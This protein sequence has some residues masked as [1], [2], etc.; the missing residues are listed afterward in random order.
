MTKVA[1]GAFTLGGTGQYKITVSNAGP[2]NSTGVTLV[3]ETFPAGITGYAINGGSTAGWTCSGTVPSVSCSNANSISSGGNSMLLL[4]VTI[5]AGVSG[6]LGA[7]TVA[8]SNPNECPTCGAGNGPVTTPPTPVA[9]NFDLA[10][11]KVAQGTFTPG[12]SGQYRI[13]VS[14]AGP[15][16]STG[17][18]TVNE[19]FPAGI[20]GYTLNAGLSSPGWTCS[21]TV[22][23]VT[24]T[25]GNSIPAG[26][27]SMLVL[28]VTLSPG[29]SNP[30]GGNTVSISNP[31]ECCPAGNGPV[32]TPPT[33][34]TA[35][36]DLSVAKAAQGT[37]LAG[38]SGQY[39]ITVSN[40][41][42]SNST[43]TTTVTETLPTGITGYSVNG[44][45]TPGWTCTGTV[46]NVTCAN[47]NPIPASG[48]S[49]LFLDVTVAS[50]A[51]GNLP[52]NQVS[53]SNPNE[54]PTCG[55]GNGPVTTPPTPVST[56]F[57]L[58]A[59]KTSVGAFIAGGTGQYRVTITNAGPSNSSGV[60]TL[61]DLLPVGI[62]G[63]SVNAASSAGWTCSGA[64]PGVTCTN[65]SVIPA[66][67]NIV[68]LLNVTISPNAPN[69]LGGN[70]VSISN[71]NECATCTGD[72]GPITTP[73][74]TINAQF[75]LAIAKTAQGT[76][77]AGGSGQ[78]RITVTN[79]GPS[80]SNGTTTVTD[81]LPTGITGYA[82]NAGS[83]AGWVCSG[84]VPNI[85]CT[86]PNIIASGG[87]SVLLLDVMISANAP[88]PLGTNAATVSNPSETPGNTG[89]NGPVNSGGPTP[90][91]TTFDLTTAKTAQGMFVAGGTGQYKVTV[92][93]NG[94]SNS[95]GTTTVMEAMPAGITAYAVNVGSSAGWN[96][97]GTLPNLTCTNSNSIPSGGNSMLVIDVTL[98]PVAPNPLGT[99]Q[100]TVINPNEC[101]TAACT[102]NNGPVVTPPTTLNSVFDLSVAKTTVGAFTLGGTGRYQITVSNAGP[103]NSVGTTTVNET[104][105][106]GITGYALNAGSTVGWVCTGAVPNVVC[107]NPNVIPSG[108]NSIL[109]LDVNIAASAPNPLGQNIVSVINPSECTTPVCNNNNGPITTIAPPLTTTFDLS[110]AKVAEGTF[111][112]GSAG[113][114]RITVSN[115]GPSNSTGTTTVN[116]TLP[117][118]IT[119]YSVNLTSSPGWTCSGA[120]P[121][122]TCTN[123][124]SIPAAGNTVLLLD[125]TIAPNASSPLAGNTVTISNPNECAGCTTGNGPVTT[126]PT[127]VTRTADVAVT[128]NGPATA[129]AGG[130]IT[131]TLIIGNNGPSSADGATVTDSVDAR[132]TGVTW[133]C[134]GAT[135]GAVCGASASGV[136]NNVNAVIQTLP[137]N[138]SVTIT[139]T[140]TLSPVATGALSNTATVAPPG[141]TTDP[142]NGNNS[143]TT[144]IPDGSI[145]RAADL[146][147]V[148]TGPATVTAGSLVSY[149][150]VV[151]NN[152]PSQANGATV[153]DAVDARI[154][155]VTWTCGS[156]SGGSVCGAG[157][158]G[159]GNNVNAV[160]Q[161]LPPAGTVT[162]TITGTLSPTATGTLSNTATVAPPTGVT[163]PVGGNNSS[164]AT[165]SGGI[166]RSADLAVAK[167]GPAAVTAGTA[168]TYTV[169][170]TNNGPSQANGATMSDNVNA[171]ITGVTWTCGSATG[172]AVC[173]AGASGAGNGINAVIQTLPPGGAVTI[174]INGT[175]SPAATGP[176]SNTASIAPPA[177]VTDPVSGN[178][179]STTTTGG[180]IDRTVDLAITKS[181]STQTVFI[182][183]QLVYTIKVTNNGPSSV[184]GATVTD[185]F[186]A[187]LTGI[188]WTCTAT[189]GS[190]CTAANGTGNI[191]ATVNLALNGMATFT[192]TATVAGGTPIGPL[193]NTATTATPAGKDDPTLANN[194]SSVTVQ[195]MGGAVFTPQ[196]TSVNIADPLECTGP[197]NVLDVTAQIT[198]SGFSA[199][200]NNPGDEFVA[201]LPA[202][203]VGV[204]GSGAA[205][206][207]GAVLVTGNRVTWNGSVAVGQTITITYKVQVGDVPPGLTQL[208]ITSV[209]NFDSDGN[210]TNDAQA[211]V[212]ACGDR[213]NCTPVGPGAP[214]PATSSVSDQKAGSVLFYNVYTSDAANPNRQN[215]RIA[216]TNAHPQKAISVHLFFVDGSSCSVADSFI[217]L[218]G[219]QTTSF[220]A[221]D[222][223]PGTTGYLV[224]V[225]TDENGCPI[226]FNFLIGDEYVKFATGHAA[227]LGAEA[228]SAIPGAPVPCDNT[229]STAE[230]KFD[231]IMYNLLP[232][233]LALDSLASRAD[234]NDTLLVLNRF[235]GNL[236]IGAATLGA[237]SGLLYNDTE[238]AY[239][240]AF[241]SGTC[242]FRST[243]TNNFPR[244]AP[245]L[246]QVIPAGRTGWMKFVSSTD[247]GIFGAAINFNPDAGVSAGAFNQGSN[248]HK[249]TLTSG[250]SV[251]VPVFPPSCL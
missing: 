66:G 37:F 193:T 126:P 233:T 76:F 119:G 33:P 226:N 184:N 147:V 165:A 148:K 130:L 209:V 122:I 55:A 67:G 104:L 16:N 142:V 186:P 206:G 26:G 194:S 83:T 177:G 89:N 227:N 156:A 203:L 7:N 234:G 111:T 97:A 182:N 12:G 40:A 239:S 32:T 121:N 129:T 28:N 112:S 218:T 115:A 63:Y 167:T 94:P 232:R 236:G 114:Y 101:S 102:N 13:T 29:A 9:A 6:T 18:T 210:G 171:L 116:E 44:G 242:Q 73:P 98:S 4:D 80:N 82:V 220:I 92:T 108:G 238:N 157:A 105:P 103:S 175:V 189:G 133:A 21:G 202:Y 163:D 211:S 139:I 174:T 56:S 237:T 162:M 249:L 153:T 120:V 118:G 228:I 96:C 50:N 247:A 151:T 88:N 22:P 136:G 62:T 152:G 243:L 123:P 199:Q 251:I 191:A 125:V 241:N 35:T 99:N 169:V 85:T 106:L 71:P 216:I 244:T 221:S 2:S 113:R 70:Q 154:T 178:N 134:G 246:E 107:T 173:G 30:L 164:T 72:N 187:G 166:V 181:A 132:I 143:S 223:D 124:N 200:T 190:S 75:D 14:N 1:Q 180:N 150:V 197:G 141:G 138:G 110:V 39:R 146:A 231:G 24:C 60:T 235:G 208:C 161:T 36:F 20:A 51:T 145:I 149:T 61:N 183:G 240:F 49:I 19:S 91:A 222:F 179:S 201:T 52:G 205:T 213:P 230:L 195:V 100:V 188:T 43:G 214:Y 196:T 185:N 159:T 84:T 217:C 74:T 10:V 69:P 225:A 250:S 95:T 23:A 25:N 245:R 38:G 90:L 31:G 59:A 41:G 131:Y 170:V 248:L 79:N 3:N 86:N 207:N 87:N 8:I 48:S 11:A 53:I 45:S 219:N 204:P 57:N 81:T 109:L 5:A 176:I 64:V 27:N 135:G 192:A 155:G 65:G 42:P 137:P 117:A 17:T 127:P 78:Y 46:P 68:L 93:N 212:T 168:I 224:A 160:I 58:T 77:T 215:T 128:K 158:S 34:T 172:G 198:N 144:T 229:S 47:G 15:S 140:G 54:C